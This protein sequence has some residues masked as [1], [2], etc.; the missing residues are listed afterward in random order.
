MI[1]ATTDFYLA[2][3]P[4]FDREVATNWLTWTQPPCQT[5]IPWFAELEFLHP[6]LNHLV[7]RLAFLAATA[8]LI[9]STACCNFPFTCTAFSFTFPTT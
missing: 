7:Q 5:A 2:T 3:V 1:E 9:W 4:L 6:S 8:A